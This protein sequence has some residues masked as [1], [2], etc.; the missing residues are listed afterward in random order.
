MYLPNHDPATCSG[1]HCRTCHPSTPDFLRDF[2]AAWQGTAG[3]FDA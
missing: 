1:A 2:D 3:V